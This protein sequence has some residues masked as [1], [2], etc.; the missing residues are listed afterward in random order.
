[1]AEKK[2][3]IDNAELMAEWD[4]EKNNA[5]GFDPR[6]ITVGSDKRVF[7]KCKNGHSWQT[8]VRPR[9]IESTKCPYCSGK[10]PIPGVNDLATTHPDLCSEWDYEKNTDISPASVSK[11]SSKKVWWKGKCGHKWQATI[12]SR[13]AGNGCP[14]CSN[15][16]V[17]VG[18][19]DLLTL[20]P[21]IASEWHPTKNGNLQPQ[22]FIIGS[23]K[24]VWWKCKTCGYEWQTSIVN[25][26]KD[27]GTGC[28]KCKL[29]LI[30]TKNSTPNFGESLFDVNPDLAKEWHPTKNGTLTPKDVFSNSSKKVWW[31]CSLGHEWKTSI[32]SRNRGS[33]C[34]EC[35]HAKNSQLH[36]TPS[37]EESLLIVNPLLA[38]EWHPTKNGTLTPEDVFANSSKK[39]WWKCALG[40]EWEAIVSSRN[41]GSGCPIC[42]KELQTSFPEQTIYFYVKQLFPDSINRYIDNGKELDVF[43]PSINI[44][45]EYDGMYFHTSKTREKEHA[46]DM[47]FSSKGITVIRVKEVDN[48]DPPVYSN[49]N[50]IYY[51]PI[52]HYKHLP[53]VVSML[54]NSISVK[55]RKSIPVIDI[56]LERDTGLIYQS[57]L[58]V[59]KEN[60]VLTNVKLINEWNYEKNGD[61]NPQY[62]PISS[63]KKVWWKCENGHEWQAVVASRNNGNN[64]PYC[65]NQKLLSG[66]NDLQTLYPS[67]AAE[68]HP[69]K[70]TPLKPQEILAGASKKVWWRCK[71]G[72]EWEALISSRVKGVGC[73]YCTNQR[74]T[75]GEND[76][77]TK[78]P[79]LIN[80]WHPTKNG[81]L[82]PSMVTCG[83][84]KKVWWICEKG[85]EWQAYIKHRSKGVG[86]PYC[87]KE[88]PKKTTNK[89]INVYLSADMSFY[90]VFDDAKSLCL[91]LD[92]DYKKQMGNIA[93]VCRRQQ[94]TLLRKYVLRY[95]NDDEFSCKPTED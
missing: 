34:P 77:A 94:K 80:E 28:P 75:S 90:G 10:K 21:K 3:I 6:K 13:T 11:A 25:R 23:G 56:S 33:S 61:L 92:I 38:Q 9:V 68:W 59:L 41:R 51:S 47:F 50:A 73:P 55:S 82:T 49:E 43:I 65:A 83:S 4:W 81:E 89:K 74:A 85:H 17:L 72:H 42:K 7:W 93:A 15:V 95:A 76:L 19:N 5:L 58:S 87:Y 27:N 52:G 40:H 37:V 71:H 91:H 60:S 66:Y 29:K 32:G 35:S 84:G 48:T 18:Y 70:N 8:S 26:T 12:G 45:I 22:D 67:V 46:K 63:G 24:K 1:M 79:E 57:Y 62:I 88:G 44:G 86:C 64:C 78:H 31:M 16:K 53:N 30:S 20:N 39:V 54:I 36:S 69:I 2:Y 14:Y